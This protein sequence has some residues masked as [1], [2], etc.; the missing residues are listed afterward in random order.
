LRAIALG[1]VGVA[2]WI[3]ADPGGAGTALRTFVWYLALVTAFL[4]IA[5]AIQRAAPLAAEA[6]LTPFDEPAPAPPTVAPPGDLDNLATE[7]RTLAAAPPGT[8]MTAAVRRRL[9]SLAERRT[10]A[11]V[12]RATI[13]GSTL[14]ALLTSGS[15]GADLPLENLVEPLEQARRC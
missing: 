1:T 7:L 13:V 15:R 10:P 6:P 12:D 4:A 3:I 5:R 14:D 2:A 11:G 9:V 8:R